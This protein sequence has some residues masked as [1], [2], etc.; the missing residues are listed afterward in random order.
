LA[1]REVAMLEAVQR[2]QVELLWLPHPKT[3]LKY[4]KKLNDLPITVDVLA[5]TSIGKTVNSLCKYEEVGAI[6]RNIVGRWKKLI[7]IDEDSDSDSEL[8]WEEQNSRR[9]SSR[10]RTHNVCSKG[11]NFQKT[12]KSSSSQPLSPDWRD[13][14]QPKLWEPER[15][16]R[17]SPDRER[18]E[19]M[20]RCNQI[21]SLDFPGS[22][23]VL[24]Q[25]STSLQQRNRDYYGPREQRDQKSGKDSGL[26]IQDKVKT[27]RE[28]SLGEPSQVKPEPFNESREHRLLDQKEKCQLDFEGQKK[29]FALSREKL[30]NVA[31][32]EVCQR[33]P[34]VTDTKEKQNGT[35]TRRDQD[36]ES[37]SVKK[38]FPPSELAFVIHT[39]K[40]KHQDT[41][42]SKLEK[43]R[44]SKDLLALRTRFKDKGISKNIQTQEGKYKAPNSPKST[45]SCV[46]ESGKPEPYDKNERP[47]TSYGSRFSCAWQPQRIKSTNMPTVVHG[48]KGH[49]KENSARTDSKS[50]NSVQKLPEM[51]D[52]KPEKQQSG[53]ILVKL[54]NV[55]T[56]VTPPLGDSILPT[57]QASCQIPSLHTPLPVEPKRKMVSSYHEE[58]GIG[59]TGQRM[60]SKMQVY[61]GPKS[62]HQY[63]VMSLHQ[64]CIRVLNNNLDSIFNFG[65]VPYTLLEPVLEK[66]TPKQLRRIEGYNHVLLG[67]TDKLW[68][69]HCNRDFN[70]EQPRECESWRELY[71]RLQEAR[72]QR[73]QLLTKNIQSAHANRAKGCQTM[74][75]FV[76]SVAKQPPYIRKRQ[77]KFG[78]GRATVSEMIKT[79]PTPRT[80]TTHCSS[81]DV[82]LHASRSTSSAHSTPSVS[83]PGT[84]DSRKTPAFK[85]RFSC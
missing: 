60:N 33:P 8:A 50:P 10:K 25:P 67:K 80:P 43:L 40:T 47:T 27:L 16:L 3:V 49:I 38:C 59:F 69:I 61:S 21:L 7:P 57:V 74:M 53:A 4:M 23:P 15:T 6:A 13:K 39:T 63:K 19:E 62:V 48:D 64:Q 73:L 26:H 75:A 45:A 81:S 22:G 56:P 14:K 1:A 51:N 82:Q 77:E 20:K 41:P 42:E 52:D 70:K 71:L 66:C 11:D 83:S 24:S 44:L 36:K 76:D 68:K 34:S 18:R 79:K 28:S 9:S 37:C 12:W 54:Q 17:V 46:L 58:E 84:C 32:R 55:S 30:P 5:K 31:S 65:N 2:L 29:N 35:T 78:T 85:N 72:E